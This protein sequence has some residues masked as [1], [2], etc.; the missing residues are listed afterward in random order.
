MKYLF[1]I[2]TILTIITSCKE[3]DKKHITRLVEEWQGKEVHFP[4]NL[5]FTRFVTD[6]VDYQIPQSDYKVLIYVD[7][8]GCTSCKLQLH[9]WKELIAHVD[10]TT[11]GQV[12]FLFIFQSKDDKELRY[13]LKRDNFTLPI[14]IDRSN[15]FNKQN[16]FPSDITFQT[17]LLDRNNKV[18][19]IGNPIHNLQI[20]DLYL[21]QLTGKTSPTAGMIK[22]T[23]EAINTD[24]DFGDFPKLEIKT[25]T[26]E[27]KNTGSSPLVIVDIS[28]TCDCTAAT[29]S[30]EPAKPGDTLQV[31]VTMTPKD[32][33]FFD[34]TVTI[35]CNTN[36]PVKVKI[37]GNVQSLNEREPATLSQT[38]KAGSQ[39]TPE[40]SV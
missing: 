21:K 7:S 22:T 29:Y 38:V 30:R 37:K 36:K 18:S 34:E 4:D 26:F 19:I 15:K 3:N 31:C 27:I 14:C 24:I 23:A 35:K 1:L 39:E 40:R 16:H 11:N 20:K 2:L 33:G 17:F 5:I 32:T 25:A 8:I 28:T 12:P 6:T 9:K 10:S 13:I